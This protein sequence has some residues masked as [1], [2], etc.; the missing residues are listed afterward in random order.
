MIRRL[1]LAGF[2]LAALA[3][4]SHT[5]QARVAVGTLECRSPGTISFIVTLNRYDCRFFSKN[6]RS[7]RYTASVGRIGYEAGITGRETLVWGVFAP[8][9]RIDHNAL[10]GTYIGAHANATIGAGVGANVLV[11]GSGRTI[12]LQPVSVE[13]RTGLS[14]GISAAGLTIH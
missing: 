8:T 4:T 10:R 3:I 9:S 14:A 7:Y 12:S 5:A 11:G 13:G 1:A 6:G 2:A